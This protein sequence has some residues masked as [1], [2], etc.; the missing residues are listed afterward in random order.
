MDG[1]IFRAHLCPRCF[2]VTWQRALCLLCQKGARTC[3]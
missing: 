3:D 2:R 1:S